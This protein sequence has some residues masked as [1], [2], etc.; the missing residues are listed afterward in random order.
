MGAS[1]ALTLSEGT[2]MPVRGRMR[3]SLDR[4]EHKSNLLKIISLDSLPLVG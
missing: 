1:Y 2:E 3:L 4:V